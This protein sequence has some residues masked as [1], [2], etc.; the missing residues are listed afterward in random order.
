MRKVNVK[1]I[2]IIKKESTDK[3][4]SK[5]GVVIILI[6]V[7]VISLFGT[8]AIYYNSRDLSARGNVMKFQGSYQPKATQAEI[9]LTVLPPVEAKSP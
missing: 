2:E 8:V 1:R 4:A 3:S 6:V 7:V 5:T 9:S